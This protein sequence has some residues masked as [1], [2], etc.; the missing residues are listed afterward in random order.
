MNPEICPIVKK[1]EEEKI[2]KVKNE[3]NDYIV[4]MLSMFSVFA[5]REK[6]P[7]DCLIM[8]GESLDS[9]PA[10][11]LNTFCK[12]CIDSHVNYGG[13]DES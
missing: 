7:S 6:L 3:P 11:Y 2:N 4:L 9:I 12:K 13:D 8:L 10:E 1:I 5:P